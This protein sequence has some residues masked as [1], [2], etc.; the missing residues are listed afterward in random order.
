MMYQLCVIIQYAAILVMLVGLIYLLGQWPSRIQMLMLFIELSVLVYSIG[1]LF[2]ITAKSMEGALFATKLGYLGK[3]YIPPLAFFFVLHYCGFKV[4]RL[5]GIISAVLHTVVLFLVL[6]CEYHDIFYT[7]I[8]FTDEGVF[9]HLVHMHGPGYVLHMALVL[10]YSLATLILCTY[11][12][13]KAIEEEKKKVLYLMFIVLCPAFGL[14]LYLSGFTR[15][16]DA[17]AVCYVISG[18]VLL[19]SISRHNFLDTVNLAKDYV[20]DNLSDGLVV[21]GNQGQFVYANMPA[22]R[23][24]PGLLG[25]DKEEAVNDIRSYKRNNEKVFRSNRVYEISERNIFH[26][27][28]MRGKM[29]F[30]QDITESFH[31][32]MRLEAEVED[33]SR[34]LMRSRHSLIVSL[35]NMVEAR[36]GVTGLHIMHTSSYVEILA[37][38]LQSHEKYENIMTD[39]YVAILKEAAPLHDIGKISVP[40]AVLCKEGSLTEEERETIR[41]HPRLGARIIDGVL[42]DAKQ[43]DYLVT[44][45]EMAYYHHERWDGDGYPCGLKGEEIPLSARIMAI[46][47]V[48]DALRAKRSYKGSYTGEE[49]RQIMLSQSGKQFDPELIEVFFEHIE[50]FEAVQ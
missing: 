2:E 43:N 18:I 28:V 37:K 50:E 30:L 46:A 32:T 39:A 26:K 44:A 40:D 25:D 21:C 34:D 7:D 31:Y 3:V 22:Q 17:V 1:Y 5:F 35:A 15:G 45:R 36:D 10:A 6:T 29:F 38:A 16:Y 8:S 9:P 23:L 33:K 13:W 48:Y 14:V 42:E 24:F 41:S 19:V 20:I 11:R 12:Y 47:D 4:S 49:A 27:D